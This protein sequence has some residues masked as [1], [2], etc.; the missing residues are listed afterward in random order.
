MRYRKMF[1]AAVAALCIAA[2]VAACGGSN[3][4]SNSGS[5]SSSN[6]PTSGNTGSKAPIIIGASTSM[7]NPV[8]NAPE[9]RYALQAGV[10]AINASGGIDGHKLELSFCDGNYNVNQELQCA[11]QI[12]SDKADVVLDPIF[13]ADV[14]GQ[15]YKL[16]Q[17]A[18]LTVVGDGSQPAQTT[19]PSVY[20]VGGGFPAMTDGALAVMLRDGVNPKKIVILKNTQPLDTYFADLELASFKAAGLTPERVVTENTTSDPTLAT[21]AAETIAGG[22]QGV[23]ALP[24]PADYPLVAKSLQAAGY[25]GKVSGI[26]TSVPPQTVT[27]MG[28]AGNGIQVVSETAFYTDTSN[29]AVAQFLADMKKYEPSA[30]VDFNSITAWTTLQLFAKVVSGLSTID[31][32]TIAKAFAGVSTPV[33]V[34]TV[35]PW[36]SQGVTPVYPTAPRILSPQVTYGVVDNGVVKPLINDFVTPSSILAQYK[37]TGHIAK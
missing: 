7:S 33:D 19:N 32:A 37:A 36:K 20:V 5:S 11:R 30:A 18:G 3:S 21:A 27:G 26:V 29:P 15:E 17:A 13:L 1:G 34:G 8:F 35:G 10:D 14:T 2:V 28:A 6:T 25:K 4:S 16:F 31:P 9:V 23:I 22:T 24:S 12:V